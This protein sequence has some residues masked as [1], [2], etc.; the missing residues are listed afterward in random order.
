MLSRSVSASPFWIG[1]T[2]SAASV[3][4]GVTSFHLGRLAARF[5]ERRLIQTGFACYAAA[6]LGVPLADP[7]WVLALPIMLFGV[8]NGINIPSILTVLTRL[9]PAEYRAAFMSVNGM[10][11]RLGQTLGPLLIGGAFA[12]VGLDG[13]FFVS[14]AVAGAMLIVLLVGWRPDGGRAA[15]VT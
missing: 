12:L 13:A 8:G 1:V 14:A 6:M 10:L 7:P 5:G 15:P 2:L 4:T 9:A 11:L 3:A